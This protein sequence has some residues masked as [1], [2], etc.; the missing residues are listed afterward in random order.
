MRV[1]R[2]VAGAGPLV[3][4]PMN[5][6]AVGTHLDLDLL[7]IFRVA[8]G[9]QG[10]AAIGTDTLLGRQFEELLTD[11]QM[12]VIPSLGAGVLRLLA[13][14]PLRFLG[15]VLGIIQVVGAIAPRRGLGASPEEIGLE[16]AFFTF[17]LFDLLLQLGDAIAGHRDGDSSNIRPAGGVRGSRVGDARPRRGAQRLPGASSDQEDQ[18]RG[19]VARATDWNQLAVHDQQALPKTAK[20]RKRLVAFRGS[21]ALSMIQGRRPARHPSFFRGFSGAWTP[22]RAD[23]IESAGEPLSSRRE[24]PVDDG[25]GEGLPRNITILMHHKDLQFRAGCPPRNS[26]TEFQNGYIL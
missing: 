26:F 16:L 13:P 11:R 18:L 2:A 10:L 22:R 14:F 6:P 4:P 23:V 17:E 5:H 8:A 9:K 15:V 19:G 24:E 7:R 12:G 3:A 20:K 1:S 21:P 25:F